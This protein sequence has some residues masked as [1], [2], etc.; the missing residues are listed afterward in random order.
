MRQLV[1][2]KPV[3]TGAAAEGLKDHEKAFPQLPTGAEDI[4]GT[5]VGARTLIRHS[6]SLVVNF[7]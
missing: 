4:G 7:T 5:A 6:V 3:M 2:I 1:R